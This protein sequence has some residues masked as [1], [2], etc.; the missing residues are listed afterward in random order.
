MTMGKTVVMGRKTLASFP[1][2]RPLK[3]R[4]NF[5]L[6]R[7]AAL[8]VDGAR[9]FAQVAQVLAAVDEYPPE[10]VFVI[11]GA[12]IY[13]LL[14]PYCTHAYVTRVAATFQAD[15]FFPNL[16]E[17]PDWECTQK[18]RPLETGGY[19]IRFFTYTRQKHA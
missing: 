6:S 11:G 1:G 3:G 4:R 12:E 17:S 5:V 10:D 2:G 7:D 18:S 8:T 14:L 19:E 15:A 9:T 13:R 16:D